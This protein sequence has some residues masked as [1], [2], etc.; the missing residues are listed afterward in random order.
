M[1]GTLVSFPAVKRPEAA[2]DL[3]WKIALKSHDLNIDVAIP[4]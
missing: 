2:C 4:P 3:P 1:P